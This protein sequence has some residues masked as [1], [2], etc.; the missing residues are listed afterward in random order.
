VTE[1]AAT[2]STTFTRP[3]EGDAHVYTVGHNVEADT[4]AA[5]E[6]R[7]HNA[8]LTVRSV[9]LFCVKDEDGRLLPKDPEANAPQ[10][11]AALQVFLPTEGTRLPA[12]HDPKAL[13]RPRRPCARRPASVATAAAGVYCNK[14]DGHD[15]DHGDWHDNWSRERPEP[16][17]RRAVRPARGPHGPARLRR[18][19]AAVPAGWAGCACLR[20]TRRA[21]CSTGP[22]PAAVW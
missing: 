16:E 15:G 20:P 13:S 10:L 11:L 8:H 12:N 22:A 3:D 21:R 2:C 9:E 18:R 14:Q 5:A 19:A 7:L 1:P 4:R 6:A 17:R